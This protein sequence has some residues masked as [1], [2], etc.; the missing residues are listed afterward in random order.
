V[1]GGAFSTKLEGIS[2]DVMGSIP[3]TSNIKQSSYRLASVGLRV[4]CSLQKGQA[5]ANSN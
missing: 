4:A 5:A 1:M 2:F 3:R